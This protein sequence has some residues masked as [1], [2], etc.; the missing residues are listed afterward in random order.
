MEIMD[1]N[2]PFIYASCELHRLLS[3]TLLAAL[4]HPLT[5]CQDGRNIMLWSRVHRALPHILV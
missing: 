1:G 4:D 3:I 5:Q 2:D